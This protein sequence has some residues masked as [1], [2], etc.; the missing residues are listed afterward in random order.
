M[1]AVT[2]TS[3][4]D[5]GT[6]TLVDVDATVGGDLEVSVGAQDGTATSPITEPTGDW[7]NWGRISIP[8]T[9]PEGCVVFAQIRSGASSAECAA[10]GWSDAFHADS[11][12]TIVIDADAWAA[13]NPAATYGRYIQF[14][15]TL[16]RE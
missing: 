12:G 1:P 6:W 13:N 8:C 2:W 16:K 7:N 5:F 15:L 11:A 4:A 14:K 10:S 3:E 9:I